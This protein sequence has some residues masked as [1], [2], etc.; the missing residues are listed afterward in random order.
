MLQFEEA[1]P[2]LWHR[3]HCIISFFFNSDH[4]TD[5][6]CSLS[7]L[8]IS[9][10]L[11]DGENCTKNILALYEDVE[12]FVALMNFVEYENCISFRACV[13]SSA[14]YEGA[15]VKLLVFVFWN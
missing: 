4:I 11:D 12:N 5:W 10:A 8:I 13:T 6:L 3:K 7:I 1:W 14:S 15:K 2:N 9:W